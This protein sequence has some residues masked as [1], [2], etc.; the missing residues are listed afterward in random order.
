LN[1]RESISVLPGAF[2]QKLPYEVKRDK[3][4]LGALPLY[5]FFEDCVALTPLSGAR[6][7]VCYQAGATLFI[8]KPHDF[9]KLIDMLQSMLH[10]ASQY[11]LLPAM[12]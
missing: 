9:H 1:Q 6:R 10:L 5:F 3:F 4:N 2:D 8:L 11:I 12:P 7:P